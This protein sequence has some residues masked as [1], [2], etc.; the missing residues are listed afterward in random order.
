MKRIDAIKALID[1]VTQSP[2]GL[3]ALGSKPNH[4]DQLLQNGLSP[5]E[6]GSML[7]EQHM[8]TYLAY[9]LDRPMWERLVVRTERY[10]LQDDQRGTL[11][12]HWG[13]LHE[14]L[15]RI[16][17]LF[18]WA[19]GAPLEN[20]DEMTF[21]E[22]MEMIFSADML[23]GPDLLT[24]AQMEQLEAGLEREEETI[25]S[26]RTGG[27]YVATAV[28]GSYDCPEVWVLRRWRDSYLASTPIG[29][30]FIRCY[31]N[32]SPRIVQAVGDRAWFSHAVR[33]PLDHVVSRLRASGY[34]SRPYAD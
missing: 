2:N 34:S 6:L 7:V 30:Q 1:D 20:P 16:G 17:I 25:P 12:S 19:D 33:W 26:T 18:G 31:Y 14:D 29:R 3:N 22:R 11:I 32:V 21:S 27:C 13:E 8:R 5:E 9:T 15:V 28:Y 24:P 10:A 23:S 4:A